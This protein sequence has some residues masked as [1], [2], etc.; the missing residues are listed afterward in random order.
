MVIGYN[1]IVSNNAED[2]ASPFRRNDFISSASLQAVRSKAAT[3]SQPD[4]LQT[5]QT[6]F[7][8]YAG[9]VCYKVRRSFFAGPCMPVVY[10]AELI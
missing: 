5:G 8:K 1:T 3:A 2:K 7:V 6:R 4:A 10:P 9:Y